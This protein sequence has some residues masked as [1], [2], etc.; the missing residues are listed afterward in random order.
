[1]AKP[2]FTHDLIP[3]STIIEVV[4][5]DS[6]GNFVGKK[7]MLYADWKKMEKQSGFIYRAFQKNY[8]QFHL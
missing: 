4:K 8:S 5:L 7:D 6:K 3:D 2:I 1:M